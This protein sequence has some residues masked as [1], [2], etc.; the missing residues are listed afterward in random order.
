MHIPMASHSWHWPQKYSSLPP[1]RRLQFYESVPDRRVLLHSFRTSTR[2]FSRI[3]ILLLVCNAYISRLQGH[4]E[5]SLAADLEGLKLSLVENEL[6]R[7]PNERTRHRVTHY[8]PLISL[9]NN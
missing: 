1:P 8:F 5:D 6:L 4:R 2:S 9:T 7:D 3:Y